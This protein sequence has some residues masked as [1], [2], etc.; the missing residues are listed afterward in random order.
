LCFHLNIEDGISVPVNVS[1]ELTNAKKRIRISGYEL[2]KI[3]NDRLIG[4]SKGHSNSAEY[5]RQLKHGADR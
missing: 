2:W 4:E 1:F 3:D 5:V